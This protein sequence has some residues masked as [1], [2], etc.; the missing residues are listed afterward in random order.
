MKYV[1]PAQAGV[2]ADYVRAAAKA[3]WM[4]AFAGMTR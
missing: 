1:T 2:H 4:P 3:A